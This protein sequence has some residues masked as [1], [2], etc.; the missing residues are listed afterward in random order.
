[1]LSLRATDALFVVFRIAQLP[2]FLC[3]VAFWWIKFRRTT[4]DTHDETDAVSIKMLRKVDRNVRKHALTR[5]PAETLYQFADRIEADT[6]RAMPKNGSEQLGRYAAWY[7]QYANAR[8]RGK[9]PEPLSPSV[10]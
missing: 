10:N 8:Y 6:R 2:L 1:L 9:L 5:L 4:G 3:L 7:R